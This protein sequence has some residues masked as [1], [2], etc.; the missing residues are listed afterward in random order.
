MATTPDRLKAEADQTREKLAADVDRL[1]NRTSPKRKLHRGSE[2][3]RDAARG[4]KERVM[5]TTEEMRTA[6]SGAAETTQEKA[7]QAAGAVRSLPQRAMRSTEGNPLAVGLIAFGAGLLAAALLPES[8][9]EQR[10]GAQLA[11]TAGPAAAPIAQA[12]KE[13]AAHVAE[14][15]KETGRAAG[16]RVAS[17]AEEAAHAT[18]ESARDQS[19]S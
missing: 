8:R 17:S 16:Q 2:R 10:A 7:E 3:I 9:A 6:A 1:A 12:A 18:R 11:S 13:S 14:E 4:A 15:A 5:G 19:R